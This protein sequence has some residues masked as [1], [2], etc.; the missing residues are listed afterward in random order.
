MH[1]LLF[2]PPVV[3]STAS[4]KDTAAG[5]HSNAADTCSKK[6]HKNGVCTATTAAT[7]AAVGRGSDIGAD[8]DSATAN[9]SNEA[10]GEGH[11]ED[12]GEGDREEEAGVNVQPLKAMERIIR[13][14]AENFRGRCGTT[15]LNPLWPHYLFPLLTPF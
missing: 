11:K 15:T 6:D 14:S 12:Q 3:L 9:A 8:L 10:K 13:G 7:A 1:V 2:Y 4:P 5:T